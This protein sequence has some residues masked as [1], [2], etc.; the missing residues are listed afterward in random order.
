MSDSVPC[1]L[2]TIYRGANCILYN[3]VVFSEVRELGSVLKML[4]AGASMTCAEADT[5]VS[6]LAI[7]LKRICPQVPDSESMS[8]SPSPLGALRVS[9]SAWYVFVCLSSVSLTCVV[10]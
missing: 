9:N 4:A 1:E 3:S 6:V 8:L 10:F 5:S 2:F 7:C